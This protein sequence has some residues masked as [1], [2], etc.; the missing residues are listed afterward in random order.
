MNVEYEYE[1]I[2]GAVWCEHCGGS[3]HGW[4]PADH[5]TERIAIAR[6]KKCVDRLLDRHGRVELVCERHAAH[7]AHHSMTVNGVEVRWT[8]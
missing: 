2:P 5:Q 4:H 3:V 7:K 8:K 6:L 1:L